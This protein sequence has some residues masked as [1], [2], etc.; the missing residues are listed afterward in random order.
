MRN[1]IPATSLLF[2]LACLLGGPQ[3]AHASALYECPG[4]VA[5]AGEEAADIL[6]DLDGRAV[7]SSGCVFSFEGSDLASAFAVV[8]VYSEEVDGPVPQIQQ[9]TVP[10]ST[11]GL[12]EE[13]VNIGTASAAFGPEAMGEDYTGNCLDDVQRQ[14]V[15]GPLTAESGEVYCF[16]V[17]TAAGG[18]LVFRAAWNGESL[19][20]AVFTTFN[21]GTPFGAGP[22]AT[23]V[24][25][26]PAP[27]LA[28]LVALLFITGRRAV[29]HV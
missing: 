4:V 5:Y 2:A 18:A 6:D 29:R 21:T 25:A 7:L 28:V 20:G 13:R 14:P 12:P 27:A 11:P 16:G 17:E 15:A 19:D 1:V 26:L 8:D 23:P 3:H 9:R 10:A 22:A 24:P